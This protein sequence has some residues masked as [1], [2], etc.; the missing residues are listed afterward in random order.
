MPE[1]TLDVEQVLTDARLLGRDVAV[2]VACASTAAGITT[3][4]TGRLGTRP[5]D[6]RT[7]MYAGSVT[8]QL[9]GVLVAQQVVAGQLHPE[10]SIV[11]LLPGLPAWA[12]RVRVRHLIHH[13][14]GLPATSRVLAAAGLA[15]EGR[16]TNALILH[17]LRRITAPDRPPGEGFAYSNVGYVVLAEI[18]AAVTGTAVPDLARDS[19][20][21]PL[22]LTTSRLGT[23]PPGTP[24]DLLPPDTVGDGGW[25]TSAVDLLTW[26][27]ALNRDALGRDV[28]HLVQTPGRLDDGTPLAYGWGMTVRPGSNGATYTHG[29]HWPGW[30]AKS[31]RHPDDGTAV[32]LLSTSDDVEVVSAAAVLLH[33]RLSVR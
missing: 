28:T 3:W 15:D 1:S 20:F 18:L 16:L 30:S 17:A 12:A 6:A 29:G 26:L 7:P 33:D 4:S 10:Q 2:A 21:Q 24:A 9:V 8:K 32:A 19:V 31:V 14:S 27:G 11:D 13:T 25:W 5:V 22:R 23:A